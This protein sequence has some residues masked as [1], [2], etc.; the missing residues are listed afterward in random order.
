MKVTGNSSPIHSRKASAPFLGKDGGW[1]LEHQNGYSWPNRNKIQY[2][3]RSCPFQLQIQSDM[4]KELLEMGMTAAFHPKCPSLIMIQVH[5][6]GSFAF[7]KIFLWT[8]KCGEDKGCWQE[9][10]THSRIVYSLCSFDT[11]AKLQ[12]KG[13]RASQNWDGKG[14][15]HGGLHLPWA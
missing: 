10:N 9:E 2:F 12:P 14:T 15:I 4:L 11:W 3:R 7:T 13:G 5:S 1:N 6:L 8:G